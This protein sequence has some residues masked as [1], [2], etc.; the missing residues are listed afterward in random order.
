[1]YIVYFGTGNAEIYKFSAFK[2]HS[3]QKVRK[4]SY[5]GKGVLSS[6]DKVCSRIVSRIAYPAS[7]CYAPV[8][9]CFPPSAHLVPACR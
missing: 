8:P 1:M 5:Q 9:S 6:R 2:L 3:P 7:F 4:E